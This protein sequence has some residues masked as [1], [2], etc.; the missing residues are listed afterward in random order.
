MKKL[1]AIYADDAVLDLSKLMSIASEFKVETITNGKAPRKVHRDP[2]MS[3][4]ECLMAHYTPT[5]KFSLGVA[6]IWVKQKGFAANSASAS[7]T[8]LVANGYVTRQGR[9]SFCFLKP[10]K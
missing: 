8:S 6:E 7:L 1:T 3:V 10:L 4:A 5:G 2:N 9:A